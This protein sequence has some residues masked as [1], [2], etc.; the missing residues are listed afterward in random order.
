MKKEMYSQLSLLLFFSETGNL[1]RGSRERPPPKK[2]LSG[3]GGGVEINQEKDDDNVPDRHIRL[4]G[5]LHS[6]QKRGQNLPSSY[7]CGMHYHS[8]YPCF[9]SICPNLHLF[10]SKKIFCLPRCG[11][12]DFR[13]CGVFD[14]LLVV[15][16]SV[17]EHIQFV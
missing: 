17:V 13:G 4:R 11:D 9:M 8:C 6:P 2:T 12:F 3:S 16:F 1:R 14:L 15:V 10:P 5:Q 7:G